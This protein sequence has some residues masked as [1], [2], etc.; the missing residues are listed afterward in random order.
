MSIQYTSSDI[1]RMNYT[2][3]WRD[4]IILS[5]DVS[6]KNKNNNVNQKYELHATGD[7]D[8]TSG[9]KYIALPRGLKITEEVREKYNLMF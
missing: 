2:D 5:S 8:V 7:C 1:T 3:V 6:H 9:R 4:S